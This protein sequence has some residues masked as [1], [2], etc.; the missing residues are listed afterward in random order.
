MNPSGFQL[1]HADFCASS[2]P[3]PISSRG[4]M[5]LLGLA[6]LFFFLL[7]SRFVSLPHVFFPTLQAFPNPPDSPVLSPQSPVLFSPVPPVLPPP[8]S[9]S[10]NMGPWE[11]S[12]V[13]PRLSFWCGALVWGKRTT[14]GPHGQRPDKEHT[15]RSGPSRQSVPRPIGA[16]RFQGTAIGRSSLVCLSVRPEWRRPS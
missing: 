4:S 16:L 14:A 3:A 13:A 8:P 9:S 6:P 2:H 10:P 1:V 5:S 12:Q 11:P 7:L 15:V